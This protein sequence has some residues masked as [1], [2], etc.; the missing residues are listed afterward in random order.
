MP[1]LTNSPEE[2]YTRDIRPLFLRH[3]CVSGSCHSAFRGGGFFFTGNDERRLPNVRARI[4]TKEPRR[5]SSSSKRPVPCSTTVART[6]PRIVRLPS[7]P[8]VD[9]QPAGRPV[10]R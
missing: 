7:H 5:A 9:R 3:G 2:R 1:V 6:S 8:G 4:D 10:Q